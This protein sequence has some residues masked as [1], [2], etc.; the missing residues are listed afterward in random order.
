MLSGSCWGRERMYDNGT[1]GG[2]MVSLVPDLCDLISP[3]E[4]SHTLN[5]GSETPFPTSYCQGCC[6][7]TW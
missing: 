2:V 6:A 1:A 5:L 3:S 4:V 7:F